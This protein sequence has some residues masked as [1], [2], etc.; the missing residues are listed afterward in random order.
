MKHEAVG[1]TKLFNENAAEYFT[2]LISITDKI[3]QQS[4]YSWG[5]KGVL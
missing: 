2:H 4:C 1:E 3:K 5:S